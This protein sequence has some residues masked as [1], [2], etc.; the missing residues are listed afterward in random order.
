MHVRAIQ[1]AQTIEAT[2]PRG[3]VCHQPCSLCSFICVHTGWRHNQVIAREQLS[4]R[5]HSGCNPFL[6]GN[7]RI[8]WWKKIPWSST[9]RNLHR[10][11]NRVF[12]IFLKEISLPAC[13][14]HISLSSYLGFRAVFLSSV[15][16]PDERPKPA[17]QDTAI[18][19][20]VWWPWTC[21]CSHV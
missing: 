19:T 5:H 21:S 14:S 3:T 6:L 18:P 7:L 11:C 15:L 4:C 2:E 8:P 20:I 10:E 13:F 17:K 9:D 12:H 1:Q 16:K